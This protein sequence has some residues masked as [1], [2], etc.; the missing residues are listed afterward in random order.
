VDYTPTPNFISEFLWDT[1]RDNDKYLQNGP[2]SCRCNAPGLNVPEI[3]PLNELN[4]IPSLYFSQGYA[5]IIEKWYFHNYSYSMPF[6]S[7][8]TWIH[9]LNT[10]RF[11]IAWT[12]EGKSEL[13]NPSDNNTNGSFTFNGQYTG[14]AL[15]D[16]LTGRAYNYTETALDPF[17][18]YRWFN[19]E[20]YFEDQMKL[21]RNLTLTAGLRYEYYQPEYS[22]TNFLGS[23]DPSLYNSANAP[24]VNPDGTLVP[25]TGTALNGIIVAGQNSPFGRYL[26]PSR[27]NNF[28]PRIGIAW[29][30]TSSGKTSIR[31]GY[32]VFYD[33]WGSY[34]QFGGFNPPF[35]S[36]VNI[37]NTLLS[38]PGGTTGALYPPGLS[39]VLPPWKYPQVQKWSF[40]VQ[41]DVGFNTTVEAAYVGTKGSHLLGAINLNQPYPNAQVA[42]G[43]ISP[44]SVRPY[45]GYSTITAYEPAFDSN[46]QALQVSAI[47]RLQHGVEFQASYTYSKTITN[48]SSQWGTPQNSRDIS[49]ERGLAS[50]DVPQVLTFNYNSRA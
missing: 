7:N 1:Y 39:A 32:G 45:P 16:F 43:V 34:S 13:A 8:N 9:G 33:R 30:P 49:A 47:H 22:T 18:N 41:R 42:N 11:G 44:D 10:F 28:A 19:L 31:A 17:G 50:F 2:Q 6:S 25:N 27:K 35:N 5:G 46:Y 29:D 20:P 3:F 37:F 4:R 12:R 24:I 48:A 36:S 14:N 38:N 21:R 15:A 26:F 40:S 23:F